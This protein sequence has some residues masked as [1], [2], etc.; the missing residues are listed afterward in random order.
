MAT[1]GELLRSTLSAVGLLLL[2]I[3]AIGSFDPS[4]EGEPSPTEPVENTEVGRKPVPSPFTGAFGVVKA[5]HK[6]TLKDPDSVEYI[7]WF[8]PT[9]VEEPEGKFWRIKVRYRAKNGFGGYVIENGYAY[10]RH[11]QILKYKTE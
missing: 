2:G 11:G 1:K 9:L 10:I 4:E 3:L 5:Y 7:S 8:Q 6:T